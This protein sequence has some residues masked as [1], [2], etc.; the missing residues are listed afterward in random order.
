MFWMFQKRAL[1]KELLRVLS[2]QTV[3]NESK[4][5]RRRNA[6]WGVDWMLIGDVCKAYQVS[7]YG[8]DF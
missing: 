4:R 2:Q 8:D 7:R 5:R 1:L 6:W 3:K